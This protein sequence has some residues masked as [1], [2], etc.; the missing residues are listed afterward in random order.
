MKSPKE[1]STVGRR[2]FGI[3]Y[4]G[5]GNVKA[6]IKNGSHK[7]GWVRQVRLSQSEVFFCLLKRNQHSGENRCSN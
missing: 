5:E 2:E 3:G 7:S 1:D 6:Y 4:D